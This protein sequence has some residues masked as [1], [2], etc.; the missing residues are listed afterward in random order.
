MRDQIKSGFITTTE[1]E[2]KGYRVMSRMGVVRGITVR[3][4]SVFGTFG[5]TRGSI[6]GLVVGEGMKLSAIGLALGL[7]AAVALTRV[8]STM[9]VGVQPTDPATY[10]AIVGLF[11]VIALIACLV[12]AR[13]AAALD[14]ANALRSE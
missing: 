1:S 3:S 11:V 4:R 5:A 9:L 14:P 6:F 10:G 13:R 8:M 7:A 2:L 12:P